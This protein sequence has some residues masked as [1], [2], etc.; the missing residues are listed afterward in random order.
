MKLE[1]KVYEGS[2]QLEDLGTV[3]QAIG[4]KGTLALIPKNLKD[5]AKRVVVILENAKGES[6]PMS[7]S[8][9]V[10]E[11]VRKAV[12][13]GATKAQVLAAI[14]KLNIMAGEQEV[15]FICAPAGDGTGLEKFTIADLAK[16][17]KV[18]EYSDLLAF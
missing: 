1:F 9:A 10:S 13:G 8:T 4:N 5:A 14:S 15:P 18:T 7:C 11:S 16:E 17:K 6:L 12:A 2:A 3:A